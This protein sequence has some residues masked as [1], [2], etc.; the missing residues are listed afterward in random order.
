V[1]WP[2]FGFWHLCT[3]ILHYQH[4]C[5]GVEA[6]R[7]QRAALLGAPKPL[8]NYDRWLTDNRRHATA[9]MCDQ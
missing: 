5:D 4:N 9:V 2:E 6:A 7:R 1:L 3:A 8:D